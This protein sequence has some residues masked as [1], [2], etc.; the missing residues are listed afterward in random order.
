MH[1]FLPW[2]Q[3][4]ST[5]TQTMSH[6]ISSSTRCKMQLGRHFKIYPRQQSGNS[7]IPMTLLL[8]SSQSS[9]SWNSNSRKEKRLR[10]QNPTHPYTTQGRQAYTN[11]IQ[12]ILG[13]NIKSN[14]NLTDDSL[15]MQ[16]KNS[17]S[18][19]WKWLVLHLLSKLC[20]DRSATKGKYSCA[21]CPG[22]DI[23]YTQRCIFANPLFTP[24]E[25]L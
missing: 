16:G 12:H 4:E 14:E 19:E 1:P 9:L 6:L 15:Y 2:M 24:A 21:Q 25:R 7:L 23:Q 18:A 8:R 3:P 17:R 10:K 5:T 20:M 13:H 22:A 11:I